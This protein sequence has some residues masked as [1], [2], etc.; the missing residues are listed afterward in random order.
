MYEISKK[1][2]DDIKKR[3]I[4]YRKKSIK[5]TLINVVFPF[6]IFILLM[7]KISELNYYLFFG[8]FFCLFIVFAVINF[9]LLS[10]LKEIKLF[11]L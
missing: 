2:Y 3:R 4:K 10:E 1:N 8:V 11:G 6:L 7:Y 5:Y 9:K